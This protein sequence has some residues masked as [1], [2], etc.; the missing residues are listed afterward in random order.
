M[1]WVFLNPS[2]LTTEVNFTGR[3]G[4]RAVA[5]KRKGVQSFFSGWQRPEFVFGRS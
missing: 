2:K 1:L 4:D 3:L 5:R